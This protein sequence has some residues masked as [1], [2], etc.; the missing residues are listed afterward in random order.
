MAKVN[1]YLLKQT[2]DQAC[3]L[4]ACRLAE[5]QSRQN[6]HVYIRLAN[7]AQAEE[8]DRLLWSFSPESFV[9]HALTS[10]TD[11]RGVTLLLGW[12]AKPPEVSTCLLNLSGE[13][14]SIQG[15]ISSVAEFVPNDQE[16]KAHSRVLWN[17]YK[18]QGH[19]LNHHQL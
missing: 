11:A 8:M 16:A 3:K 5:Q 1:F 14:A 15:N 18:S 13:A 4:L 6:Q 9:P 7:A 17:T 12:D 10:A 2:S 19:E